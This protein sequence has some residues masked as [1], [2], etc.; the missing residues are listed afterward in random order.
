[1]YATSIV[2]NGTMTAAGD[3]FA[4]TSGSF[5]TS[6]QVNSGGQLFAGT[7]TFNL[8]NVT[9]SSGSS[10]TMSA[11]VLMGQFAINSNTNISISG[12]DFSNLGNDSVIAAGDPTATINLTGNYWGT[13]VPAQIA[14]KILDHADDIT[15]PTVVYEP[16]VF[17]GS[18]GVAAS[19]AATTF[20]PTDQ[21]VDLTATVTDSAG[22]SISEGTVTFTILNGTQVI[23][24]TTDPIAVSSNT[25]SAVYTIPGNTQA[26]QYTILV[27][28]SGSSNY[29]PSSD[30]S[31]ILTINAAATTTSPLSASAAYRASSSQSITLTANL[32][33][34]AGTVNEGVVTFTVLAGGNPVGS[35]VIG[36]VTGNTASASY[37]LLAGTSGGSYRILAVYTDPIDFTTST[38][39]SS[40][41][42]SAA[43]TTIATS[44]ATASFNENSGEG[45]SLSATVSSPA[46]TVNE[47]SVTFAVLNGS[48]TQIAGP[49]VMSVSGGTAAGNAFLPA[50]T[51][52]GTYT[53]DAIFDGTASF[54]TS[55]PQS[56]TLT[57]VAP[58]AT[59][60]T[61]AAASASFNS[62]SQ[63]IPLSASVTSTAGTVNEGTVTFTIL[64]GSNQIGSSVTANVTSGAASAIYTLPANTP[65]GTYT[66]Q[67][68]Y[69][70]TGGFLGSSD[71]SHSLTITQP[72]PAQLVI[73]TQPPASITAGN[74]FTLQPVV[75]E[76]DGFGNL[77]TSDNT[78]VVTV[79]LAS[80]VGPLLGRLSAVVTG[81][82]A[83]FTTLSLDTAGTFS[84][85]FSSGNLTSA[86][87]SNIVVNPAAPTRL[88]VIEQPSTTAT[89][90]APFTT[91]PIVAEEDPY[92]NLVTSDSTDTVTV[93]HGALGTAA[94]QG[95][96][97]TV[98]L[99][100]G[101]ASFSGLSYDKAELMDLDFTTAQPG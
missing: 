96:S 30:R 4:T 79:S 53:I 83:T 1:M 29:L 55:L 99:S 91:Q 20:S 24:Q 72:A 62:A 100:Q 10:A 28:F 34:A 78:T 70:D 50:G 39:T 7:S 32:G 13:S 77:V 95:T 101:V 85:E 17:A 36:N 59:S 33:S 8:S 56:S 66:I 18:S 6:I 82:V 5:T 3:S 31:H 22:D 41:T 26:G 37:T 81:G 86:T 46:G 74:I 97:L 47:G 80:G 42:V 16:I 89:A 75:Y 73:F 67:A 25:A 51:P 71:I 52:V 27:N 38:G 48:L 58:E 44:D 64:Q 49:F 68:V 9:L 88:V 2:V 23:G 65:L 35:T 90:G 19:S 76:E 57:V 93:A 11:D 61:A 54:A 15:R 87:S 98:T 69:S 45:I 63:T 84:L 60:T 14:A 12:M 92:G 40:F 21:T 94:L 43:S